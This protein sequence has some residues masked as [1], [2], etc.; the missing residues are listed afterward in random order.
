[1]EFNKGE[2]LIETVVPAE[3]LI[4][5]RTDLKGNITY[6]NETFVEIS[7]YSLDELIGNSHNMVRHPDM[8]SAAFKD[9]WEKLKSGGK[10]SGFVK[11]LRKD[12]GHY[13]VFADISGVY[14]DGKLVEYKSLRTPISFEDKVKYQKLYDEMRLQNG[15]RRRV[16]SYIDD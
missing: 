2:F 9:L 16:V 5:S 12:T 14:K 10:W 4:V 7:G 3:Q 6:A 8:P 11:N 15:E 13:W 1:M